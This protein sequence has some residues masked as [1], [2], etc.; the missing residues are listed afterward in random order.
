[1]PD[2]LQ[3]CVFDGTDRAAVSDPVSQALV[4]RLEVAVLRAGG[5]ERGFFERF[6]EPFGGLA[7]AA[8]T[9]FA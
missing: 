9:L 2:G 3:D 7:C 4:E 1:V 5:G 8:R 6:V